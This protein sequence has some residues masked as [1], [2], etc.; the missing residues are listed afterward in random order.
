MDYYF[1]GLTLSKLQHP[2]DPRNFGPVPTNNGRIS[3]ISGDNARSSFCCDQDGTFTLKFIGT[4]ENSEGRLHRC[5]LA[6]PLLFLVVG[7]RIELSDGDRLLVGERPDKRPRRG[8][9][10]LLNSNLVT[11]GGDWALADHFLFADA[12]RTLEFVLSAGDWAATAEAE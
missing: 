4:M 11:P 9:W 7:P 1:A 10:Q 6:G 12:T 3:G 5:V 2:E 8:L